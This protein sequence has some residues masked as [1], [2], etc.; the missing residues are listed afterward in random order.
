MHRTNWRSF[1]D[2]A[3]ALRPPQQP[4]ALQQQKQ[5]QQQQQHEQHRATYSSE[6]ALRTQATRTRTHERTN[7]QCCAVEAGKSE[8]SLV[9]IIA[10]AALLSFSK[11]GRKILFPEIFSTMF[12]VNM[13]I[14]DYKIFL[15]QWEALNWLFLAFL[16]NGYILDL[17]VL[18]T[19][20]THFGN[21]M[22]SLRP[23]KTGK[24]FWRPY[25][26]NCG[27]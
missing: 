16:V 14:Y 22:W 10:M 20:A 26:N 3:S 2:W 13:G 11:V 18:S 4:R 12:L 27:N 24:I 15:D 7:N 23:C 5:Q 21:G 19:A 25:W 9:V 8:F 6:Y 1:F 17:H